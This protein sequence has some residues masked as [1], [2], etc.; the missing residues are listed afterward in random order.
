MK[1]TETPLD[2]IQTGR[3][4]GSTIYSEDQFIKKAK[5][6]YASLLKR[7]G[8]RPSRQDVARKLGVSR[9]TIYRYLQKYSSWSDISGDDR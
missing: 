6:A 9:A 2:D 7:G 1:K 5:A 3:P 4:A 8:K